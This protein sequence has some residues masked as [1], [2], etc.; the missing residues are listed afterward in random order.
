MTTDSASFYTTSTPHR[1]RRTVTMGLIGAALAVALAGLTAVTLLQRLPEVVDGGTWH[2]VRAYGSFGLMALAMLVAIR[3]AVS[4]GSKGNG[5]GTLAA[6]RPSE[7]PRVLS[8]DAVAL[9]MSREELARTTANSWEARILAGVSRFFII[10]PPWFRA[11]GEALLSH[12]A[13]LV[14]WGLVLAIGVP[15]LE[16]ALDSQAVMDLLTGNG[17]NLELTV[18]L[19]NVRNNLTATPGLVLLMIGLG[20]M[21][22]V[23]AY[24]PLALAPLSLSQDSQ[25]LDGAVFAQ[26][27]PVRLRDQLEQMAWDGERASTYWERDDATTEAS[28]MDTGTVRLKTIVES[29]VSLEE[30]AVSSYWLVP[31]IAGAAITMLAFGIYY[32]ALPQ[33]ADFVPLDRA[34][35]LNG[36]LLPTALWT[37]AVVLLA[38]VGPLLVQT[39][40]LMAGVYHYRSTVVYVEIVGSF[41]R[42]EVNVGKARSDSVESRNLVVRS[43]LVLRYFVAEVASE[44]V[45]VNAARHLIALESTQSTDELLPNS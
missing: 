7:G 43:N 23:W 37:L 22:A 17:A 25:R 44:S 28:V 18:A 10:A 12:G 35:V 29:P 36:P 16:R 45:D 6:C 33:A 14:V 2:E 32:S 38:G 27:I 4:L 42:S 31:A 15:L 24:S 19:A 21:A 8:N 39:A 30:D 13:R 11:G 1:H 26:D 34:D 41:T 40:R 20:A 9:A 3:A 5:A